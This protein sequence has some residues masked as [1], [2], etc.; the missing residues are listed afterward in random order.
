[1]VQFLR[2]RTQRILHRQ[3][4]S[5]LNV[6]HTCQVLLWWPHLE[7]HPDDTPAENVLHSDATALTYVTTQGTSCCVQLSLYAVCLLLVGGA[8]TA[9]EEWMTRTAVLA[10]AAPQTALPLLSN[11]IAHR[12]QQIV[13]SIQGS[14]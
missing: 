14:L 9:R 8:A 2:P 10:R 5:A 11:L 4:R 13:H 1:M 12:Q 6:Y 7:P 3:D